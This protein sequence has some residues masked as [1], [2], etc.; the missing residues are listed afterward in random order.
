MWYSILA[1]PRAFDGIS[2]VPMTDER[3]AKHSSQHAKAKSLE[4]SP[5]EWRKG[6]HLYY[7]LLTRRRTFADGDR[8]SSPALSRP[9]SCSCNTS[10][11]AI[12][13]MRFCIWMK[14]VALLLSLITSRFH[15]LDV[16]CSLPSCLSFSRQSWRAYLTTS[17]DIWKTKSFRAS[18]LA[19][20][21]YMEWNFRSTAKPDRRTPGDADP[22]ST[23]KWKCE[24]KAELWT[25]VWRHLTKRSAAQGAVRIHP[26]WENGKNR[27]FFYHEASLD[28]ISHSSRSKQAKLS[29]WRI[30]SQ[31]LI[32]AFESSSTRPA[33]YW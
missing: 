27:V 6:S 33:I 18:I 10:F 21:D 22:L 28:F 8:I 14:P 24:C 3:H 29:S 32:L 15:Q 13:W 25:C 1:Y 31:P 2:E 11:L 26:R 16:V 9:Q 23:C 4:R 20:R 12:L 30:S 7:F 17:C 5:R 19:K